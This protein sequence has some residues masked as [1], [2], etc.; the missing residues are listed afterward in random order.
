MTVEDRSNLDL[1]REWL[2]QLYQA[3]GKPQKAVE[4]KKK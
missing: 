1:A 4:W 2:V 3:W